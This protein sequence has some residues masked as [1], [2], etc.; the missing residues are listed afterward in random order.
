MHVEVLLPN[1]KGQASSL[2]P[3]VVDPFY[4]SAQS[5]T[6]LALPP[7]GQAAVD[8]PLDIHDNR[9]WNKS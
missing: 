1:A 3:S 6:H 7:E 2:A 4:R 9:V 5:G 8:D